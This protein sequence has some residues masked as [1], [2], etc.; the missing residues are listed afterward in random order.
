MAVDEN[1][2]TIEEFVGFVDAIVGAGIELELVVGECKREDAHGSIVADA[3]PV[4]A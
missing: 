1:T 4:Y 2:I 3:V